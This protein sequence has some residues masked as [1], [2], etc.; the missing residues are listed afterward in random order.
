MRFNGRLKSW[1]DERGFGFIE[2]A[3]G[4][5]EIFVH[6]KAFQQANGRPQVNE[7]FS[8]EVETGAK[9][10]RAKNVQPVRASRTAQPSI[11]QVQAQWGTAT[12]FAIPAFLVLYLILNV[13]WHPP[14][15]FAVVYMVS[16][17]VTFLAYAIDKAA[18][19]SQNWRV[20][21]STLHTLSLACGWPGGLLAQQF[22]RHKTVKQ[23]FRQVFW[24]TAAINVLALVILC[25]PLGRHLWS[26]Q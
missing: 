26:A 17:T 20:S 18:A 22:L 10:K 25:S 13:L 8:F 19:N 21:E 2:P 12:L 15:W 1:N 6:I 4:G 16:S 11:R 14:L 9:G 24:S 5:D 23:E 7:V 3:Q